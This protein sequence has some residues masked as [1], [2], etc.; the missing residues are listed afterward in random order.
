[1]KSTATA[2]SNKNSYWNPHR[3][4][5]GDRIISPTGKEVSIAQIGVKH[6]ID[7]SGNVWLMKRC[8]PMPKVES[9]DVQQSIFEE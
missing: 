5:D 3:F 7:T 9:I 8:K 6:C 2:R 4:T 1:M